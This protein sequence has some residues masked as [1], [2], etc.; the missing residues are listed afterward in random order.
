MS[1]GGGG[2]ANT[3]GLQEAT[4]KAITLQEKMYGQ[5][6][7]DVQ[8]WYKMGEGAV[9]TLADML[10]L[11]GGSV[12][13]RQDFYDELLPQYTRTEVKSKGSPLY[14]SPDGKVYNLDQYTPA[15]RAQAQRKLESGSQPP[16]SVQDLLP[17]LDLYQ[18]GLTD[19]ISNYGWR[20]IDPRVEEEV[21]NYEGLNA[22]V[23][24]ALDTQGTPEGYGWLLD[25]FDETKMGDDPGYQY[26]KE[27]ANKEL[28][29]QMAAQG[30]TL[31]GGGFGEI[32][33]QAYKY[34]QDLN[35]NLAA[36]EYGA[37]RGR[38]VQDQ[39]NT[40]NML[41]GGAGMGQNS[42]GIMAGS[43]QGYADNVGNLT[44]GL[45]SAQM[46]AQL[47][48]QAQSGSGSMFGNLLGLG[49]SLIGG[50]PVGLSSGALSLARGGGLF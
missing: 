15:G 36:Q 34:M 29:R 42:T 38:Y 11:T 10:G 4:D 21:T 20:A 16:E 45:A 1:K 8:P 24:E 3:A 23:Q 50:G 2:K 6:R 30:M 41:M 18:K 9:G 37:A 12:Q 22:A 39:L 26:R 31:G 40:F 5:T 33:P 46:N 49:A 28:E 44:T 27:E 43:N 17:V 13:T 48:N 32:N 35:Q 19:E 14:Y 25:R 47:A 7:E